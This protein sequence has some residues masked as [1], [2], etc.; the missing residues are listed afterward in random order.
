MTSEMRPEQ[1]WTLDC[2]CIRAELDDLMAHH[3]QLGQVRACAALETVAKR[4][5]ALVDSFYLYNH[6]TE[7]RIEHLGQNR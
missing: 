1:K 2:E 5:D 6:E 3:D 7:H 4:L